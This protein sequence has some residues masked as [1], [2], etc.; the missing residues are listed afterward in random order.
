MSNHGDT[1]NLVE[2]EHLTK[3]FAG[4]ARRLRSRQGEVHAVED[5][6]LRS[7]RRDAR[8]RRRVRLRQVDDGAPDPQAARSDLRHDPVRRP[9]HL[10]PLATRAAPAPARDADDLP[11][12]VLVPEPAQDGRAD[13]RLAVRDPRTARR[14]DT[15]AGAARDRGPQ[16]RALQPLPA[17]VLRRP[18]PTHRRRTRAGAVTEVDHLRRAGLRAGRV[19]PGA[20]AQSAARRCS[21]TST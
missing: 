4:Q 19:D 17:R 1:P 21:A 20:G 5:V 18:A 7:S 3:R 2:V 16:P 10:D 14:Q 15:R 13:R 8:D 9:G 12:S 6:S 11:G